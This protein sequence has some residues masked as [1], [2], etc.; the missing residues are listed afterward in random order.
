[1]LLLLHGDHFCYVSVSFYVFF[2]AGNDSLSLIQNP[3]EV[4]IYL[5]PL[6]THSWVQIKVSKVTGL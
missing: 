2:Q 5:E 3:S 1:M 4:L 6:K